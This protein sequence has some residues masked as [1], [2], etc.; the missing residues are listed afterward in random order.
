MPSQVEIPSAIASLIPR[1][2]GW[3]ASPYGYSPW[4]GREGVHMHDGTSHHREWLGIGVEAL[5][6]AEGRV[7]VAQLFRDHVG[8]INGD[9]PISGATHV[10]LRPVGSGHR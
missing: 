10:L 4:P 8:S 9:R 6:T 2:A 5:D 1:R 3:V 7:G